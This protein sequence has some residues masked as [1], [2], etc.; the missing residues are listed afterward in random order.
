MRRNYA[1]IHL[2]GEVEIPFKIEKLAYQYDGVT[3]TQV[4]TAIGLR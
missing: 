2:T 4:L 3:T 1:L